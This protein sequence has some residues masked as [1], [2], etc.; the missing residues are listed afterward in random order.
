MLRSQ[1]HVSHIA[2]RRGIL[3]SREYCNEAPYAV[4]IATRNR[5][6]VIQGV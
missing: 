5:G 6:N 4:E 3:E 2:L 1:R